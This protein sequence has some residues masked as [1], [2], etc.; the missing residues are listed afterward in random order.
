MWK[1]FLVV[2]VKDLKL[3]ENGGITACLE[4]LVS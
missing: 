3:K 2:K 1:E 4:E